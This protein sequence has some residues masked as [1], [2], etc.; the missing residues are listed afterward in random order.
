M[1]ELIAE[2]TDLQTIQQQLSEK[3]FTLPELV[4]TYLDRIEA[5]K[6]LNAFL[7]TFDDYALAK[8]EEVQKKIEQGTA[9]PLAGMVLGIKDLLVMKDQEVNASSRILQ[10]FE[11]QFTA[12]AVQRAIEADSIII[13]RQNCDEFGMGA[14]NENSAFGPVLNPVNKDYVSGGSSGGSAVAVKAGLCLASLGTDTGGSV[15]QPSAF[16]GVYGLKPSYGRISRYGLIAYASSFDCVGAIATNP[17]DLARILQ[18]VAGP[19]P[20]DNTSADIELAQYAEEPKKQTYKMA[21]LEEA[22]HHEAV[23]E[24][25]RQA[26]QAKVDELKSEGHTLEPV[27]MNLLDYLVASYYILITAEASSNLAR[28][29][30]VRYGYRASAVEDLE[31]MYKR[32]RSEGFGPEVK[33]RIMLGTFVLSADYYDAY[34]TRAQKVRRLISDYAEDLFQTYDFLLTPSTP[35]PAFKFGEKM[36]D[37][38]SMYMADL[39]TVFPSMTG[40]PALNIPAG[41]STE[42]L[43]IGLQ[44]VGKAFAEKQL[45]DFARLEKQ[46]R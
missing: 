36:D 41:E 43:P 9:G 40:R 16:C 20:S 24:D 39:F 25:V 38:L 18:V 45:L 29:D 14:S 35:S 46:R 4:Q 7:A 2:Q 27:E 23:H 10:G 17:D 11:S 3:V 13:G 15:R 19:D 34:Y 44:L 6:D 37:P 30:G 33:R 42:G 1:E 8:A 12:T 32:T 28:Y 31:D 26:Y 22:L 5:Q 21:Y